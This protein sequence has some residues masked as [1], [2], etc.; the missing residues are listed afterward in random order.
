MS[1]YLCA[2][3]ADDCF[4]QV[5]K[6]FLLSVASEIIVHLAVNTPVYKNDLHERSCTLQTQIINQTIQTVCE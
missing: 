1:I 4:N 6:I 5:S 2:N 3:I